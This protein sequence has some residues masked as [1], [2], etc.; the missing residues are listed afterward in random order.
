M[1]N[2]LN[3]HIIKILLSSKSYISV[4]NIA[5]KTNVSTKTIYNHLEKSDFLEY[6]HPCILEKKQKQ[7]IRLL[8][9]ESDINK[10]KQKISIYEQE[11]N[12]YLSILN[13]DSTTFILQSLFNAT[14]SITIQ[15]LAEKLYSNPVSVS[16]ILDKI[17]L[18]LKN[19][20]LNLVRKNNSGC[21]II[22]DEKDIRIAYK[23]FIIKSNI[24]VN[25]LRINTI[26]RLSDENYRKLIFI[27]DKQET[28][29]VIQIISLAEIVL[30]NK[31]TDTDFYKLTIQILI[32]IKRIRLGKFIS[33]N[34][35]NNDIKNTP[36][37]LSAQIIKNHIEDIIK[38]KIS[39]DELLYLTQ[40]IL[41]ARKQK[42]DSICLSNNEFIT[43]STINRFVKRISDCLKIDLLHDKTFI[44]NLIL[45]LI[46]AVRRSK[47]GTTAE[48][49][50]LN[51]IRYEYT[52]VYLAVLTSIE[53]L[54]ISNKIFLDANEIGYICL[55]VVA[56]INR[57]QK[58]GYIK[59]CLVC[60]NG[61]TI[62]NYLE[63]IIPRYL[64][65][66]NI[67]KKC[68]SS[69]FSSLMLDEFDLILDAT[70]LIKNTDSKII[71]INEFFQK[72]E[73]D[74]IQNWI[75]SKH[76]LDFNEDAPSIKG[77]IFYFHDDLPNRDSVL[78]KYGKYL[79]KN[80]YVMD[81]YDKSLIAREERVSTAMGRYVAVPHGSK[82][83]VLKP[84]LVIINL[85]TPVLWDD[86]FRVDLI[87]ILA[88]NFN[89]VQ[90]NKYFFSKLY[91][92]IKNEE[93]ISAIKKSDDISEI[94]Q[95]FL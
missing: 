38:F 8:G 7:G 60:D 36:E 67:I 75:L 22:G 65:E 48:N 55:H 43:E 59:V 50:L 29:K 18:W 88:V 14:S 76:L 35:N 58:G 5:L 83:L 6:I 66:I 42:E 16:S 90:I 41:S 34:L 71:K 57:C 40:N 23:D 32:L 73:I 62:T 20:N 51:K 78:N 27:F 13:L 93:L 64:P 1:T 56:A 47:Y 79:F 80:G 53:E 25:T 81:G 68:T 63:S 54:E 11:Q 52:D 39:N 91:E 72:E 33:Y 89:K 26:D 17:N 92:I 49:P 86:E 74:Y 46:P 12:L 77:K 2:N 85:K 87:F 4:S 19:Y 69:E 95:L 44:N 45:H 24:P 21:Q 31:F 84:S 37:F 10:L 28:D 61:I 9:N 30:N 15:N 70:H 3:I 94:E 82:D